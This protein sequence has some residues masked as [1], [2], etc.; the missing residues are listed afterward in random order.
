MATHWEISAAGVERVELKPSGTTETPAPSL[1]ELQF[2]VTNNG[3]VEDRAVFEI[4]AGDGAQKAWFAVGEPL[5]AVPAGKSVPFLTKI[6]IPA[7][8]PAGSFWLQG[9]VYSADT[10]PEESSRLSERITGDVP[11]TM[12][13]KSK[14][15]WLIAVA[16]LVVIVL[17]VVGWL[18]LRPPAESAVPDLTGLTQ[19]EAVARLSESGLAI[20]QVRRRQQP[21][22]ERRVIA[23]S[24]AVGAKTPA[25]STVDLTVTV[26]LAAPKLISP[27]NHQQ[28]P[29]GTQTPPLQWEQVPDAAGYN[30]RREREICNKGFNFNCRFQLITNMN[31][32][33]PTWLPGDDKVPPLRFPSRATGLVRWQVAALDDFKDPGPSSGVFEYVISTQ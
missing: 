15:W 29:M 28:F 7:G 30:V 31:V 4:V 12:I 6:T 19:E 5:L 11:P 13:K 26:Q 25:G 16:A 9:R 17:G 8:T 21:G 24:L 20:G 32:T 3:P 23:Q 33:D 22:S 1:G 2:T 18:V 10:A 14:P 27:P